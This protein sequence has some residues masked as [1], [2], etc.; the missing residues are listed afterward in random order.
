VGHTR[1][2]CG[3]AVDT[4]DRWLLHAGDAYFFR[5]EKEAAPSC[6]PGLAIFQR[7]FSVQ[8]RMRVENQQR[9]RALHAQESG[10]VRIFCAH[11]PVEYEEAR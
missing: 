1:G 11:D 9:L 4:G 10:R 5:A 3:I 6:P 8:E 2:H 7:T